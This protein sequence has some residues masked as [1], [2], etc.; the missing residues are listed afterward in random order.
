M[1]VED[2]MRIRGDEGGREQ[3]HVA[4]EADEVRLRPG[5]NAQD[6]LL[7]RFARRE[8]AIIDRVRGQSELPRAR[9]S[10]RVRTI[11]DDADDLIGEGTMDRLEIR[12]AAREQNRE[13]HYSIQEANPG[14]GASYKTRPDPLTTLPMKKNCWPICAKCFDTRST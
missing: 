13:A 3:A 6:L 1:N 7:V 12:S 8:F 11:G 9:Q 14:G 2:A 5:K 4:R 10:S